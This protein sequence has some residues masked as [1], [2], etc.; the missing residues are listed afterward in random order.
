MPQVLKSVSFFLELSELKTRKRDEMHQCFPIFCSTSTMILVYL[1][2]VRNGKLRFIW[3]AK[4]DK[5]MLLS[6][7]NLNAQHVNGMTRC[8]D[9]RYSSF[10]S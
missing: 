1:I 9:I 7:F 10:S 3:L 8:T 4:M 2:T 6:Q 5:L